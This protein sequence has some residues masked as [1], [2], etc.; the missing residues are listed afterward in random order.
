MVPGTAAA[1]PASCEGGHAPIPPEGHVIRSPT[2]TLGAEEHLDRE[3]RATLRAEPPYVDTKAGSGPGTPDPKGPVSVQLWE[4]RPRLVG[5]RLEG[6]GG[7]GRTGG[8]CL[9]MWDPG[10]RPATG[11]P[12][13]ASGGWRGPSHVQPA[14]HEALSAV[15]PDDTCVDG[16]ASGSRPQVHEATVL[17]APRRPPRGPPEQA[18]PRPGAPTMGSLGPGGGP[19]PCG[20]SE[21]DSHP[22]RP[23]T[24]AAEG[25]P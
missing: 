2:L 1:S 3:P 14:G 16:L 23:C 20:C 18:P 10:G 12:W 25:Q 8:R 24:R 7:A 11:P 5:R 15:G 17:R 6:D 22:H 9:R 13:N 19:P 21:A 4:L